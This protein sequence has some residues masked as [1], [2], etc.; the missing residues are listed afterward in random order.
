MKLKSVLS[1][2]GIFVLLTAPLFSQQTG[3][4]YNVDK[5]RQIQGKIQKI[6][7]EPRYKTTSPF[8]VLV[9][10]DQK[11]NQ[12]YNIEV[13]PVWF[14]SQDFHTGED[15]RVVG[16]YYSTGNTHNII[17]RQIRFKGKWLEL[18]DKHGFPSWSGGR[19]GGMGRH[20]GKK[21]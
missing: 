7:M 3:H 12:K 13:S 16:S 4:F 2:S 17:A 11:T 8:L 14:F 9:V 15:L 19:M 21:F 1:L 10:K 5:E 20:R 6:I 18:R